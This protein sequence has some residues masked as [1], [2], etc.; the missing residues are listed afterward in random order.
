[1]TGSEFRRGL[2]SLALWCP[3]CRNAPIGPADLLR[4]RI[5]AGHY[6]CSCGH[7]EPVELSYLAAQRDLP[8]T[9]V[10]LVCNR[11]EVGVASVPIGRL[12]TIRVSEGL[13]AL[14]LVGALANAEFPA[15]VAIVGRAQD[16]FTIV[17]GT[18][19]DAPAQTVRVAWSAVGTDQPARPFFFEALSR[20][21]QALHSGPLRRDQD[22]RLALLEAV[23]A[24]EIFVARYLKTVIWWH[25]HFA[26][27]PSKGKAIDDMIRDAGIFNLTSVTIRVAC[28][29]YDP[30]MIFKALGF[31]TVGGL[32]TVDETIAEILAGIRVRNKIVHRGLTGVDGTT[33]ERTIAAAYRLM[34]I[35]LLNLPEG[36]A[37]EVMREL[38]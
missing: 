33:V 30:Y 32:L 2:A 16:S 26:Q 15:T 20:A 28:H 22:V 8:F 29:T 21:M 34:E 18:D 6:V 25:P 37:D 38:S 12:Q 19:S 4:T 13:T 5:A 10:P 31:E 35:V 23:T 11:R 17:V 9:N 14:D 36:V 3:A 24:Y 7:R 1:M 27:S